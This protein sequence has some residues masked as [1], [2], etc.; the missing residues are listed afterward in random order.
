MNIPEAGRRL[1]RRKVVLDEDGAGLSP[2][3][4]DDEVRELDVA[5]LARVADLENSL[6]LVLVV[7]EVPAGEDDG[8]RLADDLGV[9]GDGDRLRD[10]VDA[11]IQEDDLVSRRGAVD[12]L[13]ERVRVVGFSVAGGA[14]ITDAGECGGGHGFVLGLG[15]LVILVAV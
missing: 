11:G 14:A 15:P 4:A 2:L 3:G 5:L 9:R 13:L 7:E 12:D 8:E 1:G 10:L 6:R